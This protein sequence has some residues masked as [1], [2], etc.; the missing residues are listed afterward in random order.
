M[1]RQYSR[2]KGKSGSTRPSKK[3]QPG[4]VRYKQ[5]EIELLVGR[6]A[7]AGRSSSEIGIALRDTYGIPSVQ[8]ISTKSIS[9]IMAEQKLG[10]G[11]PEDL[12]NLI[13]K[14]VAI[15]KHQQRNKQDMTSKRGLQ[16]TE[17]KIFRLIKYYKKTGK[18]PADWKYDEQTVRLYT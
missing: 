15:K 17:S 10:P 11:I 8:D 18:L 12:L 5:K 1:A 4:W 2:D 13:R 16:L 14:A 6:L 7:K 9:K 3:S